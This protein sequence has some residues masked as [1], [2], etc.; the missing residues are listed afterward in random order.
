MG[1]YACLC[2]NDQTMILY[3]YSILHVKRER[4]FKATSCERYMATMVLL[5]INSTC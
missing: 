2:G 1:R 4:F 5:F 3:F